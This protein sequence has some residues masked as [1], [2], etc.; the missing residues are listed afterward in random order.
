MF[1]SVGLS[2]IGELFFLGIPGILF[3]AE[4]EKN[5]RNAKHKKMLQV[6]AIREI[7]VKIGK[8]EKKKQ[9][10]ATLIPGTTAAG[11]G[12]DTSDYVRMTLI[13]FE[14]TGHGRASGKSPC[15]RDASHGIIIAVRAVL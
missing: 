7:S 4:E 9:L 12:Y 6:C 10:I 1:C 2:A 8:R 5:Q 13:L 14:A 15:N 11:V 3:Y